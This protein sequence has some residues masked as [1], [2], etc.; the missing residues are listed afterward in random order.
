MNENYKKNMLDYLTGNFKIEKPINDSP[1]FYGFK[2]NH[3]NLYSELQTMISDKTGTVVDACWVYGNIAT[4]TSI[5]VY[6]GYLDTNDNNYGY[7]AML[8]NNYK[9]TNIIT[10][11]E[12]GT[13]FKRIILLEQDEDLN[14]YGIEV[15]DSQ[16]ISERKRRFIMLNNF[17]I[18]FKNKYRVIL[19]KS[20]FM[21]NNDNDENLV[22]LKKIK[23]AIGQSIYIIVG[24]DGLGNG[25]AFAYK[26]KVNVGSENEWQYYSNNTVIG[27]LNI[28][29]IYINKNDDDV[30]F[31]ISASGER[32]ESMQYYTYDWKYIEYEDDKNNNLKA[33]MIDIPIDIDK[34]RMINSA[35]SVLN[36]SDAYILFSGYSSSGIGSEDSTNL[37]MGHYFIFKIDRKN[38][39]MNLLKYESREF[40]GT[41]KFFS[42]Q[43]AKNKNS[44]YFCQI[45]SHD[46]NPVCTFGQING[47]NVYIGGTCEINY[48]NWIYFLIFNVKVEFNLVTYFMQ[49]VDYCMVGKEIYNYLNYNGLSYNSE[50]SFISKNVVINDKSNDIV[51]ARN[52]Y[53]KSISD[54]VTVS[55]VEIPNLYC[56]DVKISKENLISNTNSIITEKNKIIEKNI[57]EKVYINFIN[58]INIKDK[59]ISYDNQIA[60]NYL[61]NAINQE[62]QYR[63]AKICKYGT[64][65]Y[66]DGTKRNTLLLFENI[67][68]TKVKIIISFLADKR[69]KNI[70]IISNDKETVYQ[71][72]NLSNL[73]INKYYKIYETLEVI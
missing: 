19:R 1:N 13:K 52:L 40:V 6:G 48:S 67:N 55:T 31:K 59:N 65:N 41:D 32:F 36:D 34:F 71:T 14:F 11:F 29:D 56:N 72:I 3:N 47:N 39:T 58:A 38:Q 45:S 69:M 4:D 70:Q 53:N 43:I 27:E 62:N 63:N 42:Y 18:P 33:I 10:E 25:K 2:T 60:S 73:E 50:E 61:N 15:Y 5:I 21:P 8:D 68:N 51:F 24:M 28:N 26:L 35:T 9:I 66:A 30:S 17:S 54:N 44:L 16:T 20:Y 64:I 57:Y 49:L 37:S 7:I 23:K 46:G 22:N 12:N